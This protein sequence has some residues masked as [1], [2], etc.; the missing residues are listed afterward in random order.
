MS[1]IKNSKKSEGKNKD[2]V[3]YQ[4]YSEELDGINRHTNSKL[5]KT[6]DKKIAQGPELSTSLEF[7]SNPAL[8]I[9]TEQDSVNLMAVLNRT[10]SLLDNYR[11]YAQQMEINCKK[12][13]AKYG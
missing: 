6:T 12:Y 7:K 4:L 8:Y 11:T 13:K 9:E 2:K 1:K 5:I 3:I 10:K